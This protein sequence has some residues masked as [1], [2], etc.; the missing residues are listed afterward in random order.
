MAAATLAILGLI[1]WS[2]GLMIIGGPGT[3]LG[4]VDAG[5]VLFIPAAVRIVWVAATQKRRVVPPR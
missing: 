3:G 2:V 5:T 1:C 4:L